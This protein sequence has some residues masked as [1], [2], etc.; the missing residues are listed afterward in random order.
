M[1]AARQ[2]DQRYF[3]KW[4]RNP[5]YRVKTP[6]ELTRQATFVLSAAEYV[7]GRPVRTVLDVGCG[8]GNWLAPLRKLRP[9]LQYTGVDSSE[10]A[11]RRFGK[12][13]NIRLGTIDE[14]D[15]LRLRKD[16]DL[17]LC[18]GML[19]YLTPPQLD[20]G[21]DHLYERSSGL[22]YLELFTSQD[23]GVFGDTKGTRLR[24]AA[25]Y[26]ARLR[27]ARLVSCGLHCYVPDWLRN[28]MS[29]ME[30]SGG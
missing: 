16:Y 15:Q 10:Y 7:L 3:D 18:V 4:Y 11:V 28:H 6:D 8:E 25:W 12:R 26:R 14:L 21:L 17:I 9:G 2:Y 5:R 20:R 24:S 19:N 23:T 27:K 30:Q 1:T 22:I 13:R 29:A